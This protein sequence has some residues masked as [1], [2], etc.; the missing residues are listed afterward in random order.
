MHLSC[1]MPLPGTTACLPH[2]LSQ[3]LKISLNPKTQPTCLT[4]EP[5]LS[6]ACGEAQPHRQGQR[7]LHL[8][9]TDVQDL[10]KI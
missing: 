4:C 9:H 10:G 1:Y 8:A 3:T 5:I 6:E 2:S 7:D